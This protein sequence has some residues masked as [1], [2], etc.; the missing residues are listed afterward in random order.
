MV[1][2]RWVI[3]KNDSIEILE[4][5][6]VDRGQPP[7]PLL[8]ILRHIDE[9][10]AE[11]VPDAIIGSLEHSVLVVLGVKVVE[12]DLHGVPNGTKNQCGSIQGI[13]TRPSVNNSRHGMFGQSFAGM[14]AHS[15]VSQSNAWGETLGMA[16]PMVETALVRREVRISSERRTKAR[17]SL[18]PTHWF[19]QTREEMAKA[20]GSNVIGGGLSGIDSRLRCDVMALLVIRKLP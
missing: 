1:Q 7:T 12:A 4:G 2:P 17:K 16:F 20:M 3:Q 18:Q 13:A 11:V 6:C 8:K 19:L 15:A 14:I 10:K 5:L 9:G